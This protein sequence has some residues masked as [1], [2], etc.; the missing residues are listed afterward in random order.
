MKRLTLLIIVVLAIALVAGQAGAQDYDKGITASMLA[1]SCAG[2]VY[3]IAGKPIPADLNNPA[4]T[5]LCH[6]YLAA[7]NDA[8]EW[9]SRGLFGIRVYAMHGIYTF[10]STTKMCQ[11]KVVNG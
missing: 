10:I 6:G 8:H 7:L 1:V 11:V 4:L 5:A 9:Y 2:G 3:R